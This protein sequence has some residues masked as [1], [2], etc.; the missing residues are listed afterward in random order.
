MN[1]RINVRSI[2]SLISL[3]L[4]V[5]NINSGQSVSNQIVN[6]GT[7]SLSLKNVI[8]QVI[9]TH[10]SVKVAEEAINN[11]NARIGLAKAGYYPEADMTANFSNMGP[12]TKLTIPDMGTFQL[13]PENNYSASINYRQ[14]VYDFGRT[15]QN[16]ELENENKAISE[17]T[18]EQVK[19]RLSLLTVN[20]FYNIVFLQAAIKI[21]DEQIGALNEHL[22]YVEKMKSSGS[23]TEYQLLATKVKISTVESQKVDMV[24]TL[25]AQQASLNSLLGNDKT[26][27]PVVKNELLNELPVI[28]SDSLLSYAFHNRDEVLLNEKRTSLAGL[29]YDLVKLQNKPM[30]S[31]MASGGAKN[32]YIPNL[33]KIVPNY[34][35][36]LGIRIPLFDGM[37]NKYNLYQAESAMNSLSYESEFTKRNVSNELYEAEAYMFAAG[38]KI[39]QFELQLTQ[40]LKAY[41]LAVTSFN[42]GMITNL[43]LLDANTAVSES[44][45]MLLKARIDYA[46]SVYKLKAALG[47]RLY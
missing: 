22:G 29:R 21:K 13:F 41:S 2:L 18:I 46:A 45:L 43:D 25:T 11:A 39:S 26:T 5:S 12:V 32:G 38:K 31:F 1:N 3:L 6:Q 28:P 23:A 27:T 19:Q 42:S 47:E 9:T 4:F 7:D 36:G 8:E 16:I 17:Q 24:A 40:A 33:N 44:R 14:L 30:V 15:R 35:M 10:P 34:V 37:K 20:N